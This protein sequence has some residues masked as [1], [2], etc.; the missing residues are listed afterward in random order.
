MAWKRSLF[1]VPGAPLP[2]F[3]RSQ[4]SR[5]PVCECTAVSVYLFSE[6][7]AEAGNMVTER[8]QKQPQMKGIG[9]NETASRIGTSPVVMVLSQYYN[10]SDK[11]RSGALTAWSDSIQVGIDED[12]R[13]ARVLSG[14][15]RGAPGS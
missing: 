11:Y 3:H 5:W 2:S 9:S 4:P 14:C 1:G 6:R 15:T 10:Y 8:L 7:T 13:C 12:F